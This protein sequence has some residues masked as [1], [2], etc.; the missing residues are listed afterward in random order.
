MAE[1]AAVARDILLAEAAGA[2]LH[3]A[4]I[5]TAAS[6]EWV[7][8]AKERCLPVTAE[9]APHHLLLTDE[10]V[11]GCGSL[12][13]VNPPLRTEEDRRALCQG[14]K[15]GIIDII[16]TDHAPHAAWEKDLPITEAP[17][18][19][20]GLETAVP[21]LL[22]GL[23]HGGLLTLSDLVQAYSCRPA[24]LFG[25]PGGTLR[26]GAPADLTVLKMD[27]A[28]TVEPS[29][30]YSKAKHSPFADYPLRGVPVL[31]MVGGK[32]IMKEGEVFFES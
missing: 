29:R 11:N 26:R 8:W 23:V 32:V 12:A 27:A 18:G 20:T 24:R 7:K 19:I 15:S 16:A 13:K 3:L 21:L 5:S 1:T 14:L 2:R 30:F 31:T 4:H 22:S 25:L 10:V 17:F 6:L 28:G 9:V